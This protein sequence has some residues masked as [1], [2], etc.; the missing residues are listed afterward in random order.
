MF[1]IRPLRIFHHINYLVHVST[2][3][4]DSHMKNMKRPIGLCGTNSKSSKRHCQASLNSILRKA[5]SF[6][7]KLIRDDLSAVN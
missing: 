2:Q 4:L 5:I 7:D 3:P 6:S 1:S